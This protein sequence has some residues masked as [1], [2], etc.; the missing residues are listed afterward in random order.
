MKT[1]S[2]KKDFIRREKRTDDIHYRIFIALGATNIGYFLFFDTLKIGNDIRHLLFVNILPLILGLTILGIYRREYVINRLTAIKNYFL[3]IIFIGFMIVQGA[4]GSYLSI[5]FIARLTWDFINEKVASTNREKNISLQVA[6][7]HTGTGKKGR[8]D[9]GFYY[10]GKFYKFEVSNRYIENYQ[11]LAPKDFQLRLTA[12][13][14]L[15]NYYVVD[16]W[17]LEKLPNSL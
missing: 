16:D 15:W 13:R 3:K 9:V 1:I 2:K 8:S 5:G 11:D 10:S 6:Q 7:F 14:G 4:I 12:R 17:N